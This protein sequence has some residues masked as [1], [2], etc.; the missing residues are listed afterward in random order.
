[1]NEMEM[2]PDILTIEWLRENYKNGNV[3]IEQ[4]ME[5]I[6]CRTRKYQNKNIWIVEPDMEFIA[7]YLEQ[8]KQQSRDLPLWGIPFAIKDNFDLKGVPTTAACREYAY[9]PDES[10]TVVQKL[11]QAGAVPVGK[12]NMDQFAT[13]A[14][15]TRSPYGE[16]HNAFN[17]MTISGGSSSGSAVAVALGMAAFALGSDTAGSGRVPAALNGI[18]GY[19]PTFGAVSTKGVIPACASI[20]CVAFFANTVEDSFCVEKIARGFDETCCW[21]EEVEPPVVETP[22]MVCIPEKRPEFFGE[23]AEIYEKSWEQALERIK[24]CGM[25]I[26]YIDG[27]VFEKAAEI[28]YDGPWIAERWE[29]FGDFVTENPEAVFPDTRAA[30]DEGKESK[31]TAVSL[32][33]AIHDLQEYRRKIRDILQDAVLVLPT[34]GGTFTREMARSNPAEVN[35]KL[36]LYTNHCNLL[37]M[38]AVSIPVTES[39]SEISTGITAFGLGGREGLVLGLADSF[40]RMQRRCCNGS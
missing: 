13:G 29:E 2:I 23:Y 21:S 31:Y 9:I 36:G 18:I 32:F 33:H 30:L 15:G 3:T 40:T 16:V 25:E 22:S 11:M 4:V 34:T 28:L 5:E 12:T 39:G 38:C 10:A 27:S 19:K 1:M 37:K 24:A 17:E 14:T 26:H 20:D 6:V 8:V 7:P 35:R